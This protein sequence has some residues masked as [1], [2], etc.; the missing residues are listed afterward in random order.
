MNNEIPIL[1]EGSDLV[2]VDKPSRL[3]VHNN[4]DPENL[5]TVLEK[6]L[7]LKKIFPVHRL[8]KE[9]SGVQIL[10]LNEA[11]AKRLADEFQKRSVEKIYSGILRGEFKIAKGLWAEPLSDKA[12]GRRSPAGLPKD[13]IP[14]ETGF[15]VV[16]SSRYF[17]LCEF[18]LLT[19]R[20]HQIR[21]HCTLAGHALVGDPRYGEPKYN[22]MIA[23][24][25]HNPRM[26]LHCASVGLL[27]KKFASPLPKEFTA[28]LAPL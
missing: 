28:I 14:C 25:Y 4:E 24:R 15:H 2:V 19:G 21:K 10:A 7:G 1:F 12:E 3:S 16:Q 17:T 22:K 5:L 18:Q 27:G 8:D 26:F 20:Q 9:T 11:S 13:R 23:E 6:Q